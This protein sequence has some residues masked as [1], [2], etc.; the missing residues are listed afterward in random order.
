VKRASQSCM[1]PLLPIDENCSQATLE[2]ME[3]LPSLIGAID[4]TI[5]VNYNSWNKLYSRHRVLLHK[6]HKTKRK[7]R[8]NT[9]RQQNENGFTNPRQKQSSVLGN[10]ESYFSW[11]AA[12]HHRVQIVWTNVFLDILLSASIA[13]HVFV[14]KRRRQ[15]TVRWNSYCGVGQDENRSATFSTVRSN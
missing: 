8:P 12:R 13:K 14:A 7:P 2:I 9:K 11:W 4:F 3:R 10:R 1:P 15:S 6:S 5:A